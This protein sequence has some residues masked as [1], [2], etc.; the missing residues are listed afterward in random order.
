MKIALIE[1]YISNENYKAYASKSEP[2]HLIGMYN[3]LD[4]LNHE[5]LIIDAFSNQLSTTELSDNLNKYNPDIIGF[6]VYGYKPILSYIIETIESL[7]DHKIIVVGGPGAT[8]STEY[9]INELHPDFLVVGNG[10]NSLPKLLSMISCVNKKNKKKTVII[11]SSEIVLDNVGWKRPYDFDFYNF[12]A[13]PRIQR[14]CVGNC[15]FCVGAYQNKF[16]YL[17]N[18][19]FI[20][21]LEYLVFEKGI[22]SISPL[23]PDF[24]T[25]PSKANDL[26][27]TLLKFSIPFE[28]F[29]PGVRLDTLYKAIS[30]QPNIWQDLG[31]KYVVSFESSIESFSYNRLE[32]FNKNISQI[33]FNNLFK[34]V[35]Y[36]LENCNASIILG[37]IALDPTITVEEFIVDCEGFIKLLSEFKQNITIGGMIMN[38][39]VLLQGTPSTKTAHYA[40]PWSSDDYFIDKRMK[41]LNS[42]LLNNHD[43]KDWCNKAEKQTNFSWRNEII[44][45]ILKVAHEFAKSIN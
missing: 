27:S 2:T 37:R 28:T 32:R 14:G 34:E 29:K 6:T 26:V 40:K 9:I 30:T 36:I 3:I 17:S 10:E 12:E 11:E 22:K 25:V 38:S 4:S 31:D 35:S 33:H 44:I 5:V 23:G 21:Q 45:E 1:P 42:T 13:S 18:E 41:M 7:N 39:F 16:S 24:T 8:Y 15:I 43:F 20:K 19:R